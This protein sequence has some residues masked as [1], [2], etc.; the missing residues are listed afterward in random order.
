M[1]RK[2]AEFSLIFVIRSNR[3][4]KITITTL[5]L[6]MIDSV[7][8][9]SAKLIILDGNIIVKPVVVSPTYIFPST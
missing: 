3:M 4:K 7:A 9:A 2:R 8:I 5:L 1:P 6:W